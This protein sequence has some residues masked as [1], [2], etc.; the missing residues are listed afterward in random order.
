M[1][2]IDIGI[3]EEWYGIASGIIS[4]RNNIQGSPFL[5]LCLGSIE[6]DRVISELCYKGII[7][8]RNH[9]GAKTWPCYNQNSVLTSSVIKGLEC[10]YGP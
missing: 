4:F 2:C 6:L 10:S 8:Y 7:L 3:G 9:L 5:T 1:H